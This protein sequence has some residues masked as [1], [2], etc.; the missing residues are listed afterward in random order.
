MVGV[1]KSIGRSESLY[2]L[3]KISVIDLDRLGPRC[4][5]DML[6]HKENLC[7]FEVVFG[8]NHF[9]TQCFMYSPVCMSACHH[10]QFYMH[11][12]AWLKTIAFHAFV[13]KQLASTVRLSVHRT[14]APKGNC[15]HKDLVHLKEPHLGLE[16]HRHHHLLAANC[17]RETEHH[18]P[19]AYS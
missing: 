4:T 9:P 14:R 3:G 8:G 18:P 11:S 16:S 1:S 6:R 5:E 19:N 2:R 12:A 7:L 13:I 15:N 10:V 17:E